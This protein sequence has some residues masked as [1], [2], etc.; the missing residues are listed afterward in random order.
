MPS[1]TILAG[2]VSHIHST[3]V[4]TERKE[5]TLVKEAWRGL[6]I[7]IPLF[8]IGFLFFLLLYLG[9]GVVFS[10]KNPTTELANGA[11]AIQSKVPDLATPAR[12]STQFTEAYLG[13]SSILLIDCRRGNKEVMMRHEDGD[14]TSM[15]CE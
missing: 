4:E 5:D 12:A 15:S 1:E 9:I 3:L 8:M 2:E 7:A 13:D 6:A 11:L 14:V 10:G